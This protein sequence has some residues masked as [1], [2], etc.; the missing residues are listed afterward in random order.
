MDG[1]HGAQDFRRLFVSLKPVEQP[2]LFSLI[3][4]FSTTLFIIV[5]MTYFFQTAIFSLYL[6][7]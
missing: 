5:N 1:F 3:Q 2:K 7:K 6:T 4:D